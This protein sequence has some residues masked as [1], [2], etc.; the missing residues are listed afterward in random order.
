[1]GRKMNESRRL[2]E[3]R[4]VFN[5]D[6]LILIKMNPSRKRPKDGD[7][8][9]IQPVESIYCFG[10]VVRTKVPSKDPMINGGSLIY[11]YKYF[12]KE[13]K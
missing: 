12:S 11:I 2:L 7:V 8:F 6:H 9:V 13:M 1:M 10:I 5:M 4:E 3:M